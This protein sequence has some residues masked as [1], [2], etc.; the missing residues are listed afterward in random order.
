MEKIC[1]VGSGNWGSCIAKIIGHN[2]A[3]LANGSEEG[4]ARWGESPV[5]NMWVF[6]ETVK[7]ENGNDAKLSEVI[8]SLHENIKY[9][10][11]V[12]L[13]TCV[14]AVPDLKEA[15]S[16]ATLLVFVLPHQFVARACS[17]LLN[18][19]GPGVRAIS[20]IK[21]LDLGVSFYSNQITNI[22]C[23]LTKKR[24]CLVCISLLI[25]QPIK[26]YRK[27]SFTPTTLQTTASHWKRLVLIWSIAYPQLL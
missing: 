4:C 3:L 6:E 16:D 27:N 20:L 10:P 17:Q 11:G 5:V 22:F 2:V 9:L 12:K 18:V 24:Y 14:R 7:L 26:K 23:R 21:G 19:V 8:N 15:A 25:K 1:I 13:P